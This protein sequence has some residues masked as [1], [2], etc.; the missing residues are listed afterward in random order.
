V[1]A[2]GFSTKASMGVVQRLARADV[3]VAGFRGGWRHAERDD[4]A[5][6]RERGAA[7]HRAREL[8]VARDGVVRR[9][10]QQ[11]RIVGGDRVHRRERERGRGA[12]SLRLEQDRLGPGADL[13][14]LLGDHEPVRFVA[15]DQ[16]LH[17]ALEAARARAGL[18]Q[19]RA[20]AIQRVQR[21]RMMLARERPQPR[22]GAAAEDHRLDQ[23][24]SYA[25]LDQPAPPGV[26]PRC[27][28]YR[29]GV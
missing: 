3:A 25:Q 1:A 26:G 2:S 16:G 24:R 5:L 20:R 10:H 9:H 21:L 15:D 19:Q 27:R 17:G 28:D 8:V 4:I 11:Y 6:V 18:L 12:A 14:Q 29:I 22:A 23:G 7:L 13:L